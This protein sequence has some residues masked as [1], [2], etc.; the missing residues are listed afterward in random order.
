MWADPTSKLTASMLRDLESGG[1][2]EAAHVVGDMLRRVR[3]AGLEPG[4][5]AAAWCHL[6]VAEN[7]V[8]AAG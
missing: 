5:L 1:P 4:V 2:T 7:R 3:D 6:Q 8:R